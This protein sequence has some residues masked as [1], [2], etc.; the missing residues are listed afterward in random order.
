MKK[1]YVEL[2]NI[3]YQKWIDTHVPNKC[4]GMCLTKA[5][6]MA[7]AFPELK[8]VGVQDWTSGHA[9]CVS[10]RGK[11]VDPTAHQFRGYHYNRH[12]LDLDDFPIGKCHWCGETIWKDTPGVRAHVDNYETVGPHVECARAMREEYE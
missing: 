2:K 8:V 11:V 9:W 3:K 12:P 10:K 6:A 7:K 5:K 4:I 1:G